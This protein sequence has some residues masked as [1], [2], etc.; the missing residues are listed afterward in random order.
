MDKRKLIIL[1][2]SLF[3]YSFIYIFILCADLSWLYFGQINNIMP[4]E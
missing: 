3:I 1:E 2:D 4:T